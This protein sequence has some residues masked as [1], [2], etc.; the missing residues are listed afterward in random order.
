MTPSTDELTRLLTGVADDIVEGERSN[1]PDAEQLWRKGRRV[2]WASRAAAAGIAVAV[3]LL[4]VTGGLLVS[5]LPATAPATGEPFTYP[6]VVSDLFPGFRQTSDEP[7]FGLVATAPTESESPDSL[8]IERHGFLT[9]LGTGPARGDRLVLSNDGTAPP[10]APDGKRVLTDLG[11]TDDADGSAV[12]VV[13]VTNGVVARPISTDPVIESLTSSRGVWGPDSAHVLVATAYGPAVLDA[14]AVVVLSPAPGDQEVRA[15]GWRDETTLL[16]VRPTDDG[17]LA[18]VTRGLADPRWSTVG[19]VAAD[20]VRG[21]APPSRV[22]AAPD[23]SRLL[24]LWP[25]GSGPARSVLVDARTGTRVPFAGETAASTISWD[26]CDP[27]WQAGQPLTAQGGLH[28]P[29]TGEGIMTFSG[30]SEHGCVSL[31]GNELTGAPAPGAAGAWQE[32]TW[33]AWTA[34][35]PLGGVLAL[36]GAVWMVLALR[37]SR[38]HG[39]HFL[40]MILRLPF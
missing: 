40:P 35:L 37:R 28:R 22:F 16:G 9:S 36:L 3:M 6:Q 23:G 32:R 7:L 13:D 4:L 14:Q 20:A 26:N 18:I 30:H 31:A 1:G 24:L 12:G 27:V 33:R 17:G 21:S 39:E 15:A 11:N 10:L 25:A 8:V 19:R 5:G 29:A 2:T 38:R 34:A